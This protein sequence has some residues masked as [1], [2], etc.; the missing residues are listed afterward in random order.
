MNLLLIAMRIASRLA[1]EN[2]E[3]PID[4]SHDIVGQQEQQGQLEQQGYIKKT[5]GKGYCVK[6]EKSPSWN[7]G[8]YETKGEAKKRLNQVEMFKHMK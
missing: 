8:C 7:G 3:M 5:K 6:S 1:Q 4:A 2:P